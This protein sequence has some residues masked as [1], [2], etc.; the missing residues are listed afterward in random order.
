M[1]ASRDVWE[2]LVY[3]KHGQIRTSACLN[4]GYAG[5]KGNKKSTTNY[6]TFVGNN[7][8]ARQNKMQDV[9][10]SSVKQSVK[11][12]LYSMGAIVIK[13]LTD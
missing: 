13:Q 7:L 12:W 10:R 9:F 4:V 5:E 6:L 8:V 11:L 1:Y 2:Q 3:K